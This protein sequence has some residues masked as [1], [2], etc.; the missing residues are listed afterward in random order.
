M[1]N[2][3]SPWTPLSALLNCV[4]DKVQRLS[5]VSEKNEE[6]CKKYV[7]L[8]TKAEVVKKPSL[9]K[10]LEW[11]RHSSAMVS[12]AAVGAALAVS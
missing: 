9:Y 10:I 6:D 4:E 7:A 11:N 8:S 3:I 12:T 2:Q 5:R 1:K